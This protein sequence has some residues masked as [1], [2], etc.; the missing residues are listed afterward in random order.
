MSCLLVA[1]PACG[2]RRAEPADLVIRN[3]KV[4]TVDGAHPLAEAVAIR[5]G[6]I[7]AVGDEAEVGRHVAEATR[8]L[9][10]GGRLVLPGF[11]DSHNHITFGADPDVAQLGGVA[12][13]PELLARVR[14]FAAAHPRLEWIEGEGW[15]Y[16]VFPGGRLPTA[17]DLEGLT[18]G[19]PAFLISYDAHTVWLNREAIRRLGIGRA[20]ER[21]PFGE[22]QRDRKSGEA[23][24]MLESFAT[25]G[26]S[27]VGQ[28]ALSA[29]IPSYSTERRYLRLK[30][31]MRTAAR[32]G[33]TTVV[34][35]QAFLEDLPMFVRARQ[36]GALP[37]R[38][39]IALFH[40]RGTG[41]ADLARF[42]EARRQYADDRMRVAAIKLYIDDVI[43]PHTAAMLEPYSDLPGAR[44]E[45]LYPPEEFK[46]VVARIDRM[47]FQMFIHSIGDRGIRTSL[48]A[49]QY[50]RERN[51]ARDSRHQ[52]VHIECLSP[53]D[54]PRFKELG[55][56]A[57]MQPRHCA[58]DITGKWAQNVGPERS[59]HAWA[60]RSLKEAGATLAFASDWNV[61]E[62]DPLVGIYT[63]LT[64]Q[65]LDG[66][67][68]GGWIPDQTIDL[69]T[70]VRAYTIQGAYANFVEANRGSITPGKYADLVILSDDLFEIPPGKVKDAHVLLTLVGGEEVY[71]APDL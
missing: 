19:R 56:V 66:Q 52:L 42:D 36:E 69:E 60:F 17:R 53:A 46:E 30:E 40:P 5:G 67:P 57:C 22:V 45:T 68:P 48:D 21:L 34:E 26:L 32:F 44:G 7:L 61:A 2:V 13:L 23:T 43:E 8:V 27:P 10:A 15:N 14:D 25:M 49:L 65:G 71:R 50:A 16:S 20:T 54:I 51:G 39:Q 4:H 6:R 63:A 28:A 24:G 12:T 35:P 55:V 29:R 47:K 11:I 1:L 70:A 64:R 3:A 37:A 62:M 38:L 33:I 59:R 31:N 9:D 41:E 58:P 18:G